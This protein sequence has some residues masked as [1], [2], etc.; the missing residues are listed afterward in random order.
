MTQILLHRANQALHCQMQTHTQNCL[1]PCNRPFTLNSSYLG[2]HPLQLCSQQL[3]FPLKGLN[4]EV[5]AGEK[6]V[7]FKETPDTIETMKARS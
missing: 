4:L 7:T 6:R 1:S 3:E 5:P 2:F